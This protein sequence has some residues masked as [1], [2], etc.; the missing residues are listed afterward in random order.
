LDTL[1]AQREDL[2]RAVAL[3]GDFAFF[4]GVGIKTTT[5]MGMVRRV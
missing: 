3:L 1:N 4:C 2:A 5:G